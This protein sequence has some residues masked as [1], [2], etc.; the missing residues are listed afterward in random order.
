[1]KAYNIQTNA[2]NG[3]LT[4]LQMIAR[5]DSGRALHWTWEHFQRYKCDSH[6]RLCLRL[7]LLCRSS[8]TSKGNNFR[9]ASSPEII[10]DEGMVSWDEELPTS[11]S[12]AIDRDAITENLH[13]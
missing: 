4:P 5:R 10:S 3:L 12:S 7:K 1:M 6:R 2:Q 13:Q 8:E 9:S 11:Q